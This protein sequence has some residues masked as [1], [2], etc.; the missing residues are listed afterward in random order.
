MAHV[1]R[2]GERHHGVVN[3]PVYRASTVTFP[4]VDALRAATARPWDGVTYGRRGTPTTFALQDAMAELEGGGQCLALPSG[5]A[6]VTTALLA[7]LDA[8]DHLLMVDTVYGPTR[9]F[10]DGALRSF[11]VETT[12]YA[13][14]ADIEPLFRANTRAVYLE[15]PGSLTF[16]MQDVPAVAAAA[17]ARGAWTLMDNTWATPL[18]CKPL[19]LGVDV[20]IQSVTKYVGGHADLMMGTA[21]AQGDAFARLR[22]TAA[23]LGL[24][25]G[26]D[27]CYLALR[28]LR[29][30]AARLDRHQRTG[31]A[32]AEWLGA[33]PEVQRVLHPALPTDPGHALWSRDYSGA[34][35]LFGVVLRPVP[36]AAVAAMVE[37]LDLFAMGYSWGGF[38]S[39]ALPVPTPPRTAA[40]PWTDDGP[41][42]RFH[43]GLED[44]ADLIADLEAGLE[45]LTA[46]V[47]DNRAEPR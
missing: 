21:T 45:R 22:S 16:E 42:L 41:L 8:G 5:L 9:L 46:T 13:P 17:R 34:S 6:A 43:A 1:G 38:E 27:D 2:G 33:R 4:S 26:P 20:S 3:P 37:G 18:F 28:G 32:L 24:C 29:T 10:C 15:S 19:A 47:P 39:L 11:G 14:G 44:P 25:A 40:G 36:D 35:G 30:L 31:L 7:L 12:Y 23:Q